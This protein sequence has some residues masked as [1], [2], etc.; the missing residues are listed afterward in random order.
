MVLACALAT[1]VAAASCGEQSTAR[2]V[3]TAKADGPGVV[4]GVV[5]FKGGPPARQV[6]RM[7]GD[8][9]CEP[10]NPVSLPGLNVKATLS[11]AAIVGAD[12]G[13]ANAFVYVREGLGDRVYETPTTPVVLD[14]S[15]CQYQPH[16]F[17]VFVGQP[18]QIRNSDATLHNVHALPKASHE[19]NFSEPPSTE[20][21]VRTFAAAEI[22]V[23]VRCDV[24]RWMHAWA[25]VVT[26]PF[27]GVT[28]TDGA[29]ELKGLP[30][31][32]YTIEAWHE[33]FGRQTQKVVISDSSP[34]ATV[35]FEFEGK[36]ARG[37][38]H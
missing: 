3:A 10:K 27:F 32:A 36:P 21:M 12:G 15:G 30:A 13:V 33:E 24:H 2:A 25:N 8:P 22:G 7:G 1:G 6:V 38:P 11:E 4:K 18:V 31:G 23:P 29:F 34:T 9:I 28:G 20:P 37:V 17:G 5:S 16:V 26:H 35:S 14:Q 19:F